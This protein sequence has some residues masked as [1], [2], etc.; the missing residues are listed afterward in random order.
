MAPPAGSQAGKPAHSPQMTHTA[1]HRIPSIR[2]LL[3]HLAVS[4][5]RFGLLSALESCPLTG[6]VGKVLVADTD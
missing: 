1:A 4:R 2:R 5:L 3:A 6:E